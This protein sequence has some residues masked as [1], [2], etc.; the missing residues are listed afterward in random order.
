M[1]KVTNIPAAA[2]APSNALPLEIHNANVKAFSAY[3]NA[4]YRGDETVNKESKRV[5]SILDADVKNDAYA[6]ERAIADAGA[7]T[8]RAVQEIASR[9]EGTTVTRGDG[10]MLVT[11][12]RRDR[13][14]FGITVQSTYGVQVSG[15][16][17]SEY[18]RIY[19]VGVLP[20]HLTRPVKM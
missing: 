13:T 20:N 4:H 2:P 10:Y 15:M 3:V 11:I 17:H 14:K 8:P 12:Q 6:I 18:G 7:K 9:F 1:N 5:W 16:D 19:R